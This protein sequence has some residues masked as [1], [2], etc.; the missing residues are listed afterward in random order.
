MGKRSEILGVIIS[1]QAANDLHPLSQMIDDAAVGTILGLYAARP[2]AGRWRD[3][4]DEKAWFACNEAL[5]KFLDL[6]EFRA[7]GGASETVAEFP[8]QV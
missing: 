2:G 8:F 7:A 1:T 6:Q 3:I 4:F 5:G